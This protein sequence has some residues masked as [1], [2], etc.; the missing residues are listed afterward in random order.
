MGRHRRAM[1]AFVVQGTADT[2]LPPAIGRL[3]LGQWLGVGGLST[4]QPSD[5]VS[6]AA[7]ATDPY[8]TIL[9]TYGRETNTPLISYAEVQ[10]GPH[11]LGSGGIAP[12]GP[13]LDR[14]FINFL[15]EQR[16]DE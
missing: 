2:V 14:M 7:S 15:L 9:E 16:R 4:R 10:G 8:P 6:I 3:M 1:P 12:N 5:V 11:V 13:A